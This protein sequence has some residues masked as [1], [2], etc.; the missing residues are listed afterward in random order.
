MLEAVALY[1]LLWLG[2]V[3]I[4]AR[5]CGLNKSYEEQSRVKKV[6]SVKDEPLKSKEAPQLGFDRERR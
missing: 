2:G 5:F 6:G 1:T 4:V 3:W